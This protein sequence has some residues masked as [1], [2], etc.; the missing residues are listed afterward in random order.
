M[1][2]SAAD[3]VTDGHGRVHGV[4]WLR[5]ADSSLFPDA[6]EINPYLTVMSLADRA[7]DAVLADAGG[8]LESARAHSAAY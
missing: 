3:S 2:R 4:P 5:V 1:G 8:L 7:A 6:L